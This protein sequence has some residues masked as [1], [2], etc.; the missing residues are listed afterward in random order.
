MRAM[1]ARQL[2]GC[3]E[4]KL[5]SVSGALLSVSQDTHQQLA[6]LHLYVAPG[7]ADGILFGP[8]KR[9]FEAQ[10]KALP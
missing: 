4:H 8:L 1:Y 6:N 5:K 7:A 9:P 2:V 3:L 10:I